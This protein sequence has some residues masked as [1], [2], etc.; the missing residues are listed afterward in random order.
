MRYMLASLLAGICLAATCDSRASDCAVTRGTTIESQRPIWLL[1]VQTGLGVLNGRDLDT[2]RIAG[3]RSQISDLAIA[4][5]L[6]I[7]GRPAPGIGGVASAAW[8]LVGFVVWNADGTIERRTRATVRGHSVTID[9][10]VENGR[11]WVR[12]VIGPPLGDP[13]VRCAIL[14]LTADERSD[15][16]GWN[17][18]PFGGAGVTASSSAL[19]NRARIQLSCSAQIDLPGDRCRLVRRIATRIAER[20]AGPELSGRVRDLESSGR[21]AVQRG[22]DAMPEIVARFIDEVCR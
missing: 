13:R 14:E 5:T 17:R 6:S 7:D 18:G 4:S 1:V 8:R 12:V 22:E 9:D 10:H 19:R 20:E 16:A 15:M 2:G 11:V 21:A 3:L